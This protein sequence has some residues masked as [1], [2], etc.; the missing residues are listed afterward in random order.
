MFRPP[1]I[2]RP[3]TFR[4][5]AWII[6]ALTNILSTGSDPSSGMDNILS[7]I[8][9]FPMVKRTI[10]FLW[11][12]G[13]AANGL[14]PAKCNYCMNIG[15][16]RCIERTRKCR[17]LLPYTILIYFPYFLCQQTLSIYHRTTFVFFSR[18]E[19]RQRNLYIYTTKK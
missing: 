2:I 19:L 6:H 14:S 11:A 3:T 7:I 12:A 4:T 10:N 5:G 16:T 13:V 17:K 8:Y 1:G 9:L 18:R 15:P